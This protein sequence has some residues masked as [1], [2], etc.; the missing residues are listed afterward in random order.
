M[1]PEALKDAIGRGLLS[2]PV[3]HMQSD[4]RLNLDSY[5]DHVGWLSNYPAAVLFAAGGT[6]EFHALSPSEV[7]ETVRAAKGAAGDVPIVAGCGYGTALALEFAGAAERAGADGLL[8]LPHYLVNAP[9][10]GI[11]AHVRAVCAGTEL[12][13]IVYNRDNSII[14][15]ET[16]ERLADDC[17]NLIGFKDGSGDIQTVREITARLGDRLAYIGGMP[18]H[19]LFA[20]AYNGTGV[21]T[22]S[23]A[24]F[25]FVPEMAL[26]FHAALQS[27]DKATMEHLLDVFFF[28]F[29]KLRDRKPGYAVSLIKAGVELIG[30]TPGGV[31]APLVD[32]TAEEREIL[33]GLIDAVSDA[34]ARREAA[35]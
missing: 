13:V 20:E 30:R 11:A 19:E 31:R 16:L 27:G 9:Q 7:G 2:F 23:S 14:S 5:A 33:R 26:S 28:P 12:G 24:V 3:T 29:A 6:G 10:D 32:P 15:A 4:G 22:Y 25:N 17:P 18:T 1:T 35:E 21:T 34:G 8:L